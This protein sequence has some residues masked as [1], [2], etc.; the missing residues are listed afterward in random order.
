MITHIDHASIF[1]TSRSSTRHT[2]VPLGSRELA[3]KIRPSHG[4]SRAPAL[5]SRPGRRRAQ[6]RGMEPWPIRAAQAAVAGAL[7]RHHGNLFDRMFI[8]QAQGKDLVLVS[9]DAAIAVYPVRLFGR[10]AGW[11][12]QPRR[13]RA[14]PL[15]LRSGAETTS[16]DR[17]TA[18]SP[19]PA[20]PVGGEL[21]ARLAE[22]IDA[23]NAYAR[24]ALA[25]KTLGA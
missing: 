6:A 7:L 9:T 10:D 12:S 2:T 16:R 24:R 21:S 5:P 3:R 14:P 1:A 13:L 20:A 17:H 15:A 11:W 25:L 22:A 23:A 4:G 18:S 19:L 8:A